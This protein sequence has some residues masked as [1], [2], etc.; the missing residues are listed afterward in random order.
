[1]CGVDFHFDRPPTAACSKLL[2]IVD[3][4]TREALAMLASAVSMPTAP[5]RCWSVWPPRR[6][7]P[8]YLRIDN[9]PEMTAHALRDWCVLSRT[10]SAYIDPGSPWQNPYVESFHFRVRDELLDAEEFSCLAEVLGRD[11]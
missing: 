2:N 4:S 5:W 3:E 11:R 1:M 6:R 8:G 7:A 9:G 10:G